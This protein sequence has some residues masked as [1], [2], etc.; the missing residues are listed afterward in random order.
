MEVIVAAA[1]FSSC[2]GGQLVVY[3]GGAVRASITKGKRTG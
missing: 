1:L 3:G 2:L